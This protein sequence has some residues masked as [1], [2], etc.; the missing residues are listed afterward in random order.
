MTDDY[1][2]PEWVFLVLEAVMLI[3]ACVVVVYFAAILS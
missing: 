1:R 2:T 3:A